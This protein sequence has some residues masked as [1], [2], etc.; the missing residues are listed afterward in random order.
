MIAIQ[1]EDVIGVLQTCQ[2]YLIALAVLWV[3]AIIVMI[4]CRKAKKSKK[5]I[6]YSR[7]G[8]NGFGSS[9]AWFG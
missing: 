5:R 3:I 9:N 1:W 6:T 8:R 7:T 2:P 4:A